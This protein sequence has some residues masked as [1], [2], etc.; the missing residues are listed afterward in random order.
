MGRQVQVRAVISVD[1]GK[2]TGIAVFTYEEGQPPVLATSGEYKL[3]D[4]VNELYG[5]ILFSR[6]KGVQPE[7][8][9]ERFIINAQTVKNSQAPFS[10]E[11]IGILKYIVYAS[12]LDPE[13]I[14]FQSPAD[15]K[16]M[17]P[18]EALKK[19]GYWKTGTDGHDKDAM[20]HGLLRLVKTGWV[21]KA[22]LG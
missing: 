14:V 3:W 17:F 2:T 9:C 5:C 21:P 10:L 8:V 13:S 12:A 16:K 4:V 1:P 15:A 20:R 11:M 6:D 7:I 18:N 19:L 22:L